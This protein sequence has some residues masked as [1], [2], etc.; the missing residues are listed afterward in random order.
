MG[1]WRGV[2]GGRL[3]EEGG[4]GRVRATQ[5]KGFIGAG[6]VVVEVGRCAIKGENK[7]LVGAGA[8]VV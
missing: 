7:S 6:A 8:V 1:E 2:G 4:V 3:A 5:M